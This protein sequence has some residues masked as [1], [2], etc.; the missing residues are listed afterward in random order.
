MLHARNKHCYYMDRTGARVVKSSL[1]FLFPVDE[2]NQALSRP[3]LFFFQE[4]DFITQ[5]KNYNSEQSNAQQ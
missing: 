4:R 3:H 2:Y 1:R 5:R